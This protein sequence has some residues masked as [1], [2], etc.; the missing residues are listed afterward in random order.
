MALTWADALKDD[1]I[2]IRWVLRLSSD[3]GS[4]WTYYAEGCRDIAGQYVYGALEMESR[5]SLDYDPYTGRA[6]AGNVSLHLL[7]LSED[8]GA[9][10]P[11]YPK[12]LNPILGVPWH[13]WHAE[14]YRWAE[15]TA[16]AQADLILAGRVRNP[17][18]D[19]DASLSLTLVDMSLLWD[20]ALP[21]AYLDKRKGYDYVSEDE[22]GLGIPIYYGVMGGRAVRAW[23]SALA[24]GGS[25]YVF[26]S[27]GELNAV[28][29]LYAD[30]TLQTVAA[31]TFPVDSP[32][33]KVVTMCEVASLADGV[34]TVWG[35]GIRDDVGGTVSGVSNHFLDH[36]A[37][38]V[39]S[40]AIHICGIPNASVDTSSILAWYN[41]LG[42]PFTGAIQVSP[43]ESTSFF[44]ITEEIGALL[45]TFI[46]VERGKL[47]TRLLDFTA[48]PV[49]ALEYGVNVRAIKSIKYVDD[50]HLLT[51]LVLSYS[52]RW[53]S[54]DEKWAYRC[55]TEYDHADFTPFQNNLA[56]LGYE[57][58]RKIETK[59]LMD[60]PAPAAP[61][62]GLVAAELLSVLHALPRK[63]IELECDRTT[64]GLKIC[65][66]VSV[67]LPVGDSDDGGGWVAKS[68][69]VIGVEY[70]EE[71]NTL[72]LLEGNT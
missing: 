47:T 22:R 25:S 38:Q 59:M 52:Y 37:H 61:N 71:A 18:I 40:L 70:G 57:Q 16:W 41:A 23:E 19:A 50:K 3:A 66:C 34:V 6:S 56:A 68:F 43:E 11:L 17:S 20:V 21:T 55:V 32:H 27:M 24:G 63:I 53:A 28:D 1:A 62:T 51:K 35:T 48:S 9:A 44:K 42:Y 33:G 45:R 31:T 65:N 60:D 64:H 8:A 10:L 39:H 15:G 49:M 7:P 13:A 30:T 36:I 4:T 29:A 2:P 58:E 26:A 67:T 54:H 46:G 12:D 14:L 72:T 69:W 5:P